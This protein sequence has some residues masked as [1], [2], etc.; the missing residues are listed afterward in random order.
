MRVMGNASF[1][2]RNTSWVRVKKPLQIGR[3]AH[4]FL[5]SDA[6]SRISVLR[7]TLKDHHRAYC[8]VHEKLV[9]VQY[10]NG[11]EPHSSL[12]VT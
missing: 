9:N 1:I 10:G 11:H 7:A 5:L 3:G 4:N 12:F 6:V 2:R 8:T